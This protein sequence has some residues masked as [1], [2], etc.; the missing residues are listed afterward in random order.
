MNIGKHFEG[1][2]V[3]LQEA[4]AKIVSIPIYLP[5]YLSLA[6]NSH[7]DKVKL[8]VNDTIEAVEAKFVELTKAY[9]S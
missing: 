6:S 1:D 8:S 4:F 3:T 2:Q 5:F 7:P 9:K